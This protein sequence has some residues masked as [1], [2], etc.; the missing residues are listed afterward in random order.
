MIELLIGSQPAIATIIGT[1][2]SSSSEISV[3]IAS[4]TSPSDPERPGATTTARIEES[5]LRTGDIGYFR[6]RTPL[7]SSIKSLR[8]NLLLES[9]SVDPKKRIKSFNYL[10][11]SRSPQTVPPRTIV[12]IPLNTLETPTNATTLPTIK[13]A[14]Y[15]PKKRRSERILVPLFL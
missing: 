14:V 8:T 11:T 6:Y 3:G 13:Y 5:S 7:K 2:S 1:F 9:T 12:L 4:A 15:L 10:S